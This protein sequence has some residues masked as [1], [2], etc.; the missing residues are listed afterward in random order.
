M[1]SKVFLLCVLLGL[2]TLST[3]LAHPGNTDS[4][5]GHTCRTNCEDWGLY[6]GEYHY[7]DEAPAPSYSQSDYDDGYQRGYDYA[8]SYT[9]NCQEDYEYW[10]EGPQAFGDG[11]EAGITDGHNDGLTVCEQ[12][13]TELTESMDSFI[14]SLEEEDTYEE[15]EEVVGVEKEVKSEATERSNNYVPYAVG[16]TAGVFGIGYFI[17]KRRK[18]ARK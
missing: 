14:E 5:G 6:Y 3:V 15:P 8:Y 13:N 12:N 4:S 18:V 10:W 11:Y 17:G 1:K 9:S 2:V 7:H 16:G